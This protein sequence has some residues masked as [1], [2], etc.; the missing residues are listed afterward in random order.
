MAELTLLAS[1]DTEENSIDGAMEII[2]NS[3]KSQH[4]SICY[5]RNIYCD[6]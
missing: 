4:D 2:N 1:V 3:S 6:L 5:L